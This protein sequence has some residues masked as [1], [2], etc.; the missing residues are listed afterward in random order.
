MHRELDPKAVMVVA[1]I[2]GEIVGLAIWLVPT[3][4][5][6]SESL[7]EAIYRKSIEYK[8]ALEDWMWPSYWIIPEKWAA[9]TQAQ[10]QAADNHLGKGKIDEMWYLNILAVRP[11]YQRRGVGAALLD[12]GLKHARQRGEKVYLEA[13]PTG[14]GLYLKKGFRVVGELELQD[15]GNRFV[16][17]CMLWDP[18]SA[19]SQEDI[20]QVQAGQVEKQA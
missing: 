11:G 1:L 9:F 7:A 6:R 3:P 20:E 15:P 8:D 16:A 4:L 19:P 2:D 18:E 12:W 13:S 14:M 17:P 5:Q 10:K